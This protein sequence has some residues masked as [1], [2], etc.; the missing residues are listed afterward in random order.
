MAASPNTVAYLWKILDATTTGNP[1]DVPENQILLLY[2]I[3]TALENAD[4]LTSDLDA[5]GN[6]ITNVNTLKADEI[7]VVR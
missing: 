3:L 4:Q 7:T 2:K 1:Q 6:N 5:G